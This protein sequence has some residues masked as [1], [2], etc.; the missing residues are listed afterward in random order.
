[1]TTR[2]GW[3]GRLAVALGLTA[4]LAVAAPAI[5]APTVRVSGGT[6][7]LKLDGKT[8]KSL[9]KAGISVRAAKPAKLKR[10]AVAFPIGGGSI[11]PATAKG[12]LAL[13]GGLTL[14]MGKQKVAL[15]KLSF[16]ARKGFAAKAGKK[17]VT[18]AAVK[19]GKVTRSGF[20]TS[21]AGYKVTFSKA[22]AAALNKALGTRA[23]KRGAKL[24]VAA[25]APKSNEIAL[26]RG[27][28]TLT[29]APQIAGALAQAGA[30]ISP[31]AP[32]TADAATGALSFPVTSGTLDA[33]TLAG[34]IKHAGGLNLGSFA[35]TDLTVVLSASPTLSTNLGTIADLDISGLTKEVDP[36]ARTISRGNV[37]IRANA[38]AATTIDA[39]FFGGRGVLQAGTTLATGSLEA[40]AR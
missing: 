27:T 12:K 36:E 38:L 26:A 24:G 10:G 18:F 33:Q 6:T 7:T 5:A 39:A 3:H 32:A 13:K 35:L 21:A 9:K 29:F 14:K 8:V 20:A 40:T 19:G 15:S 23:F 31:I 11:D 22:G 37:G 1:M 30:S 16:D 4:S 28:T 25:T 2:F 34:S 17:T